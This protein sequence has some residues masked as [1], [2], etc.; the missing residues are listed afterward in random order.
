MLD[1]TKVARYV[2]IIFVQLFVLLG[3]FIFGGQVVEADFKSELPLSMD[4]N[5]VQEQPLYDPSDY[6][7]KVLGWTTGIFASRAKDLNPSTDGAVPQDASFLP[8]ITGDKNS[9][10]F[11]YNA[12]PTANGTQAGD[13]SFGGLSYHQGVLWSNN[14]NMLDVTKNQTYSMWV[15]PSAPVID[16]GFAFVIQNDKSKDPQGIQALSTMKDF[17]SNY[18]F[19]PQEAFGVWASDIGN[20]VHGAGAIQNSWALEIDNDINDTGKVNNSFDMGLKTNEMHI[21]TGFPGQSSSYTPV[22]LGAYALNQTDPDYH[23]YGGEGPGYYWHHLTVIFNPN[24]DGKTA[25]ITYKFND[26]LQDGSKNTNTGTET[27]TNPIESTRTQ[28]INLQKTFNLAADQTKVRWGLVGYSVNSKTSVALESVSSF[29]DANITTDTIDTTQNRK[30]DDVNKYVNAGDNMTLR[31]NLKYNSG[32]V[33]W[34]KIYGAIDVPKNLSV[35]GGLITYSD[36][37][38]EPISSSEVTNGTVEH[39]LSKALNDDNKTATVDIHATAV[40]SVP[41]ETPVDG[42]HATFRGDTYAGDVTTQD[43]IIRNPKLNRKLDI[44]SP[45]EKTINIMK[46]EEATITGDLTYDDGTEFDDYGAGLYVNINGTDQD[47][48]NFTAD[49]TGKKITFG[50]VLSGASLN[51]GANTV[52]IYA[53]DSYGIKSDK[54]TFTINVSTKYANVEASPKFEFNDMNSTYVG[55]VK[56]KGDWNVVVTTANS[57]WELTASATKLTGNNGDNFSGSIVYKDGDSVQTMQDQTVKIGGSTEPQ[58][59]TIDIEKDFWKND[60]DEGILLQSTDGTKISDNYTGVITWNL[61]DAP[62]NN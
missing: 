59:G 37:S 55:T 7:G 61:T 32:Q 19:T 8:L 46:S 35:A 54:L 36:G 57:P 62:E 47:P 13:V 38:T 23:V 53:K 29:V 60:S 40:S 27:L 31:F 17:D 42:T 56:R 45:T 22:G 34:N 50:E 3:V 2:S 49:S 52:T 16:G 21:S 4:Y 18:V 1:K 12:L 44:S 30:L 43:F 15:S 26:K 41:E 33:D 20:T 25:D 11:T 6:G 48:V 14:A 5:E 58:T 51:E 10:Q 28:T 24:S 9:A 39:I